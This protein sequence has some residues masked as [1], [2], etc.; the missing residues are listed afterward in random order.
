VYLQVKRR[1]TLL[2]DFLGNKIHLLQIQFINKGINKSNRVVFLYQ[3]LKARKF[4]LVAVSI[5]DMFHLCWFAIQKY[6]TTDLLLSIIITTFT[7]KIVDRFFHRLTLCLIVKRPCK[8]T[9]SDKKSQPHP[10][11]FREH[12]WFCPAHEPTL[13]KTKRAIFLLPIA[14]GTPNRIVTLKRI[15]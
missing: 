5:G 2:L 7:M 1:A 14:I 6:N 4:N 11:S 3:S 13:R 15:K 12:I 10:E 8:P 9:D